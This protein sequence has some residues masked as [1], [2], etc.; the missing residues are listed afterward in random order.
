[1]TAFG[2]STGRHFDCRALARQI[3]T[4][5]ARRDP[6]KARR[7]LHFGERMVDARLK[8]EWLTSLTHD[9][10]SDPAYRIFHNALMWAN[11][12]GTDGLIDA[13][14]LRY[15]YPQAIEPAWL[16]ELT[17]AAFWEPVD[18][19]FLMLG[20]DTVLGQST[21]ENVELQRERNRI[22]QQAHRERVRAVAHVAVAADAASGRTAASPRPIRARKSS[23]VTG[24]V[25]PVVGQD[26]TGPERTSP[27]LSKK[28]AHEAPRGHECN[29]DGHKLVADGTCA[30]CEYRP[31]IAS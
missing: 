7:A 29:R 25:T 2:A 31:E 9:R 5:R 6:A 21:A 13:R 28:R 24:Y 4:D 27:V 8:G 18:G 16:D 17:A 19:G 20:W 26:R 22:K 10:L 23:G 11:E 15:L 1:M 30:V 3:D 12:Q 14:A